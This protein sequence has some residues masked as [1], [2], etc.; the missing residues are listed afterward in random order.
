MRREG[1]G[2]RKGLKEMRVGEQGNPAATTRRPV[3]AGL[4]RDDRKGCI[5]R[6]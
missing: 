1:G 4:E 5:E 2:G 6:L 3:N